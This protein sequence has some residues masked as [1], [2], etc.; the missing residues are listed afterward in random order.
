MKFGKFVEKRGYLISFITFI[1]VIFGVLLI[2]VTPN[3]IYAQ[4]TKTMKAELVEYADNYETI[5][6]LPEGYNLYIYDN[7]VSSLLTRSGYIVSIN[8]DLDHHLVHWAATQQEEDTFYNDDFEGDNYQYFIRVLGDDHY[9]SVFVGTADVTNFI[10]LFRTYSIGLT[11][12]L[13]L[14]SIVLGIT[15]L[16]GRLIKK[17]SFINDQTNFYNKLSLVSYFR[18]KELTNHH[19]AYLNIQ[20]FN[21][22]VDACGVSFTDMLIDMVGMRLRT[23]F[24]NNEVYEMGNDEYVIVCD[25]QIDLNKILDTFEKEMT[26][27]AGIE[28]YKFHVKVVT[29]DPTLLDTETISSLLKRFDYGYTLIK[30]TQEHH[31]N[32][33]SSIVAKMDKEMYYQ[34]NLEQAINN[35][36]IVNYYQP[37]VN[38]TTNVITGCEALSRWI[39]NGTVISPTNYIHI[40]EANGLVY[41]I[42][43]LSFKNSCL[44]LQELKEKGLLTEHFKISTNLSPITLKN[45]TFST[46]KEIMDECNVDAK[47]LSVEITESIMIDFDKVQSLLQDIK[48]A[49]ISIEIDDFSAGN[50]SFTVLPLLKADYLKLDM[51]ILPTASSGAKETLIYEGLVDISKKLGFKLISEGVE[52]SKQAKY[53]TGIKVDIIQGYYYSKPISSVDFIEFIKNFK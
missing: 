22:I 27:V 30:S 23:L 19:I 1:F 24:K 4:S 38:P 29:I 46:L 39:D 28:T 41:K 20:N 11:I 51:A 52:T 5:T 31:V 13:Y 48:D 37:K 40:A 10:D 14:I 34:V 44:M 47:N 26:G 53:V 12:V 50:S 7:G 49:N 16:S 35:N 17:I 42:D 2:F 25:K 21:D 8:G 32:V 45:L 6:T 9:V 36:Q 33:T 43:L 15:F 18:K 3:I